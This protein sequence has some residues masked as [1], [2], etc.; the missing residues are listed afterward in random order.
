M[1][2][3]F[4]QGP[5]VR[6]ATVSPNQVL[7][8]YSNSLQADRK[9]DADKLFRNQT[10]EAAASRQA[11]LEKAPE[12][13]E[14]LRVETLARDVEKAKAIKD[15]SQGAQYAGLNRNSDI[16]AVLEKDP[17]YAG[18]DEAGKLAARN[19]FSLESPSSFTPV[20][21]FS[22]TLRAGLIQSGKFTGK[23][24]DDAVSSEIAKR[25]PTADKGII[26]KMLIKPD[27][28][29]GGNNIFNVGADGR[30]SSGS[31]SFSTIN[32]PSK[33]ATIN[34]V[35]DDLA[36]ERKVPDTPSHF[37]GQRVDFESLPWTSTDLTRQDF[38]DIAAGIQLGG[39]VS[40]PTAIRA[41]IV[42]GMTG[43]G[44][45][46]EGFDWRTTEGLAKFRKEA[47]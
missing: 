2:K 28:K 9:A 3:I 38:G 37:L 23:E 36:G 44:N 46:K 31:G 30:V 13:A 39:E 11:Y 45:L 15:Y 19:K 40:S 29:S 47:K 41:A 5:A 18:L 1:P 7:Q 8:N 21:K 4:V 27:L 6:P 16:D 20:K 17:T 10:L 43:E 22:D 12:R 33:P 34:S 14:K 35:L 25:Y 24:I 32:D 26:E 42:K